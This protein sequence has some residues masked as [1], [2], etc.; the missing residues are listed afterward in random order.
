[1]QLFEAIVHAKSDGSIRDDTDERSIQ[2]LERSAEFGDVDGCFTLRGMAHC[3]QISF[4]C[5]RWIGKQTRALSWSENVKGERLQKGSATLYQAP[6]PSCFAMLERQ[7]KR[8][9]YCLLLTASLVLAVSRGNMATVE[10]MPV[11]KERFLNS[12]GKEGDMCSDDFPTTHWCET[13]PR[14][15]KPFERNVATKYQSP[16]PYG[17]T[18]RFAACG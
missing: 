3:R 7:L 4:D 11:N 8:L 6:M 10:V 14:D 1:M 12:C 9:L 17:L 5:H 2:T 18:H 16:L 13:L 15:L